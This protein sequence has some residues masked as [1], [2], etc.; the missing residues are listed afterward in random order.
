MPYDKQDPL[1]TFN[2]RTGAIAFA[3]TPAAPRTSGNTPR[4][5]IN[6]ISSYIDG[7][8]VYGATNARLDWLRNGSLDG[9]PSNNAAT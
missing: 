1:E 7:S 9:D 2:S 6:T 8:Q 4:Q 3:R 5:Q